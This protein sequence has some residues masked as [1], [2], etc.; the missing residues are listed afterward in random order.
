MTDTTF[1][2]MSTVI[3]ASWLQDVNNSVYR[4]IGAAATPQA[5]LSNIGVPGVFSV[6][7]YGAVGNG[8]ADDTAAIAATIAAAGGAGTILFPEGTYLV[9]SSLTFTAATKFLPGATIS[10]G[11]GVVLA[12]SNQVLAGVQHIFALAGTASVTASPAFNLWGLPEWFG[13]VPG[14][15]ADCLAAISACFVA[16]PRTQLQ[17]ADYSLSNTLILQ[18]AGHRLY[19]HAKQWDAVEGD[20][21]RLIATHTGIVVQVGLTT[22]PGSVNACPF[23][24]G[25]FD[26]QVTR[27]APPIVTANAI[28][29]MLTYSVYAEISGVK[30]SESLIELQCTGSVA[31]RVD[32]F[33]AFRSTQ[34]YSSPGVVATSGN[35]WHGIYTGASSGLGAG[36]ESLYISNSVAGVGAYNQSTYYGMLVTGAFEDLYVDTFETSGV[37]NGLA[38]TGQSAAG[39]PTFYNSDAFFNRIICDQFSAYGIYFNGINDNGQITLTNSYAAPVP[40]AGP[41]ACLGVVSSQGAITVSGCQWV[42]DNAVGCFGVQVASSTNVTAW[43]NSIHEGS[44]PGIVVAASSDCSFSDNIK[45]TAVIRTYGVQ[46]SGGTNRCKFAVT[47]NGGPDG[48]AYG[49]T[50]D[51]SVT[52]CEWNCSGINPTVLNGG[53]SSYKLIIN[54]VSIIAAGAV[55]TNLAVGIM[56]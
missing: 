12:F 1:V 7:N 10:A 15:G 54:G 38:V 30:S 47:M 42:I 25:L 31:A 14:T 3:A 8:V 48:I 34:G 32:R 24:I 28:G 21:T 17:A 4:G 52:Y 22:Y 33:Y 2:N 5:V 6:R 20:S 36:N 39:S 56:N 45:N 29:I 41:T 53:S 55:G 37:W 51:S 35:I 49:Y 19:G 40:T 18:T 16:F 23:G 50:A 43:G 11:T 26:L 9:S 44:G 13:A 27:S 46:A